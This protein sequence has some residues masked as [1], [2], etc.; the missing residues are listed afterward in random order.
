MKPFRAHSLGSW[1]TKSQPPC[2]TKTAVPASSALTSPRSS[3]QSR[4]RSRTASRVEALS[5]SDCVMP[6]RRVPEK[7]RAA[8]KQIGRHAP[9]STAWLPMSGRR[10]RK[11]EV[12]LKEGG[13]TSARA[14]VVQ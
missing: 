8:R 6:V 3:N 2:A 14:R 7:T 5:T 11:Q 10:K 12:A 4:K 1:S 13:H 9:L